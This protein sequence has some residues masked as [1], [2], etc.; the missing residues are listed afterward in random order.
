MNAFRENLVRDPEGDDYQFFFHVR[1]N[2][3]VGKTSLVRQWEAV[4][5]EQGATTVYL[6]DSVHSA[7]EVM[8][9]IGERLGRQGLEL[10]RFDKLLSTFRQRD[11]EAQSARDTQMAAEDGSVAQ[12][13]AASLSGSV[14]AQVGLV[15]LGMVPVVGALAGAVDPQQVAQGADRLRAVLGAPI[16]ST[17]TYGSSW[18][19]CA[20]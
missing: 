12:P 20:A 1:G 8:E 19:R 6:D 10:R 5:L 9:E 2:A 15:G 7:V 17:T 13:P 3:G 14:A 16:R 4:A 18:T 11:H